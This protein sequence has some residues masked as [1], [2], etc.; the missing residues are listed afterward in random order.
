MPNEARTV[1]PKGRF[2]GS[3]RDGVKRRID[4]LRAA[5]RDFWFWFDIEE[6]GKAHAQKCPYKATEHKIIGKDGKV[7]AVCW[8]GLNDKWCL[9]RAQRKY[10]KLWM[11]AK[12][13]G[14]V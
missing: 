12:K 9:K 7:R 11:Q 8:H 14:I 2:T 5:E 1:R 4:A 10:D 3:I 6:S 13:D